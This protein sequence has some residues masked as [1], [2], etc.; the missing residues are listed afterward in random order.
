MW[1]PIAFARMSQTYKISR[2]VCKFEGLN[3]FFVFL[4]GEDEEH[5]EVYLKANTFF[6]K[7][8]NGYDVSSADQFIEQLCS[9]AWFVHG[10]KILAHNSRLRKTEGKWDRQQTHKDSQDRRKK[11]KKKT[12]DRFYGFFNKR[13]LLLNHTLYHSALSCVSALH[14][15]KKKK[16]MLCFSN[17][18]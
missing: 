6:A 16:K 15:K 12:S 10:F 1:K 5:C 4:S 3:S 14:K 9:G 18:V 11:K 17:F 2:I 7:S 13:V 8:F